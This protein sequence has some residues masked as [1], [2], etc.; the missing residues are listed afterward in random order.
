VVIASR[1]WWH[2]LPERRYRIGNTVAF[3]L[4]H[5]VVANSPAVAAT[6]QEVD[7]INAGRISVIPNFVEESAF[8]PL[9]EADK[10]QRLTALGI[11]EDALVVGIVAR[12][13]PVKD[14]AS[15]ITAVS[16]LAERWPQLHLALFGD[17]ECRSAIEAQA[18]HLRIAERAH[19]AG[20]QPNEPN[21]HHLFDISVLCSISEGFPNSIVE[22][23]AAARPIV[24]TH[25]GGNSDAVR[26]GETGLLV[27]PRSPQRLAE[28]IDHLLRRADLRSRMGAAAQ[29]RARAVYHADVV[30]P[31]LEALYQRLL[32]EARGRP[33]P[34]SA[35]ST[36]DSVTP[37][38]RE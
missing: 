13:N 4:A 38:T 25:V 36:A 26:H 15:L 10:R 33:R 9:S 6:L 31:A 18:A 12:L 29:R 35:R 19:F 7:G 30:M 3:R 22:A 37:R 2:S 24:A 28:A 1:R 20:Q 32:T 23:M 21:P 11:P 14:H 17:G 16:F 27:P 34:G 8:I 5:R